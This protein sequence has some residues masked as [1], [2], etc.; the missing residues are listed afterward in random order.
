MA[1]QIDGYQDMRVLEFQNKVWDLTDTDEYR[2][3]L[4]RFSKSRT[5]YEQKD[6]DGT[7]SLCRST[8]ENK[9]HVCHAGASQT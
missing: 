6:H 4:D 3:L 1:L 7:A 9:R 5:F 8:A 2:E